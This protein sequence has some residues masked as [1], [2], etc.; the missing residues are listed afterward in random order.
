MFGLSRAALAERWSMFV[1]A[2]VSVTLGVSLVQSS[3]LLLIS[4]ATL[5]PPP[6]ASPAERMVFEDNATAAVSVLGVVLGAATF[7]AGFGA[8]ELTGV[9]AVGGVVLLAGGVWCVRLVIAARRHLAPRS[10]MEQVSRGVVPPGTR[11]AKWRQGA[12]DQARILFSQVVITET[13][14]GQITWRKGF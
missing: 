1:G 5:D 8:A 10:Q 2:L 3:L 14:R 13:Q 7:L 12:H 4:A 6:G 11:L 9:R